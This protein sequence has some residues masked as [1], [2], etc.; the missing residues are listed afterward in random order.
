MDNELKQKIDEKC[1]SIFKTEL[2]TSG[3]TSHSV[4]YAMTTTISQLKTPMSTS[5]ASLHF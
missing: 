2:L 1:I 3:G 5:R 4:L